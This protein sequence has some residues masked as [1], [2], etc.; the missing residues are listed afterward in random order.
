ET[1]TK[2]YMENYKNVSQ[3]IRDQ[4][5]AEAE[6]VQ[7]IL[8]WIDNDIYST[9]DGCPNACEMWKTIKRLKQGE[10]INVQDVETN[11]YWEFGNSHHVMVN[12]LNRITQVKTTKAILTMKLT[13]SKVRWWCMGGG[14]GSGDEVVVG[15]WRCISM[16]LER[17]LRNE[18]AVAAS[19]SRGYTWRGDWRLMTRPPVT[20]TMFA[21]TTPGNMPFAYHASTS[22][23]PALMINP[24][25]VEANHDILESLLRDRRRRI[26]NEYVRT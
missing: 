4:I 14:D 16:R 13:W 25:L 18:V 23:D 15:F 1:T 5:N 26:H 22:T 24:T 6:A 17:S 3:D 12:H 10:S 8:T 21:A 2:R 7:I 11:L 20:T 19:Q 9:V